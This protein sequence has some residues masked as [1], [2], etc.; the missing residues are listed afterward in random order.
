MSWRSWYLRASGEEP[1]REECVANPGRIYTA[2]Q[3]LTP[4]EVPSPS[5]F[6]NRVVVRGFTQHESDIAGVIPVDGDLVNETVPE[7]VIRDTLMED[8]CDPAL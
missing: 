8:D 7:V 4:P 6:L 1:E 5:L 2:S 3:V